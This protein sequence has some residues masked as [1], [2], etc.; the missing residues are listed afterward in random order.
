MRDN[1]HFPLSDL[2]AIL[3]DPCTL[4]VALTKL[5]QDE[6]YPEVPVATREEPEASGWN[7]RNTMSF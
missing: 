3:C 1:A 7:L 4:K 2:R 6:R 5:R